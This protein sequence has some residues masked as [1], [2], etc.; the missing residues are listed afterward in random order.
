MAFCGFARWV[1]LSLELFRNDVYI[2]EFDKPL[3]DND[4][5][6]FKRFS[7]DMRSYL[8]IIETLEHGV[9]NVSWLFHSDVGIKDVDIG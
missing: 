3:C 5:K 7:I 1:G 4:T 8:W 2:E 6:H 9:A